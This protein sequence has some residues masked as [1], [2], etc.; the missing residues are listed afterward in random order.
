MTT[1]IPTLP[2]RLW[3]SPAEPAASATRPQELIR[4]ATASPS[5]TSTGTRAKEAAVELGVKVVTRL[6]VTDPDS[7]REF[8]DLVE[9]ASPPST[10]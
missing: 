10:C 9:G 4:R 5:A 1:H 7:F 8:L 6:D 2:P 3:R